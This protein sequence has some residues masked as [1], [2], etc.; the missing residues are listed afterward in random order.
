MFS[1]DKTC[2]LFFVAALR[3]AASLPACVHRRQWRGRRRRRRHYY[4]NDVKWNGGK[5]EVNK[6]FSFCKDFMNQKCSCI[7][8][9]CVNAAGAV[10][11]LVDADGHGLDIDNNDGGDDGSGGEEATLYSFRPCEWVELSRSQL[12][13]V[14]LSSW[15][16]GHRSCQ[17]RRRCAR[18]CSPYRYANPV[19]VHRRQCRCHANYIWKSVLI[20]AAAAPAAVA[21]AAYCTYWEM[22]A[23]RFSCA[24]SNAIK[25][26]QYS[27]CVTLFSDFLI[28]S[29]IFT[30]FT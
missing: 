20:A 30:F 2:S 26:Q 12:L 17:H 24:H 25:D 13:L 21:T 18:K 19:N 9:F 27:S 5:K 10:N 7:V 8:P 14:V 15:W 6:N 23:T 22:A 4:R 28:I 16:C 3:C 1:V 29:L 11:L